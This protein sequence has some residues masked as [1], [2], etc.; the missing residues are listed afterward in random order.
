LVPAFDDDGLVLE[1]DEVLPDAVLGVLELLLLRLLELAVLVFDEVLDVVELSSDFAISWPATPP[2]PAPTTAPTGP[3]TTAPPTAPD[4]APTV[5]AWPRWV[6]L[7]HVEHP[8]S[9]MIAMA[10]AVLRSPVASMNI[11][12]PIAVDHP[13]RSMQGR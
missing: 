13:M 10:T 4:A 2:T 11:S 8:A 12:F 6:M 5:V 1:Y 3:P 9:A 7:S